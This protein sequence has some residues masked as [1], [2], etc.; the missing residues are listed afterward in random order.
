VVASAH[1][2]GEV[3]DEGTTERLGVDGMLDELGLAL[4]HRVIVA[5]G[6]FDAR[7]IGHG[8]TVSVRA[9]SPV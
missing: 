4:G 9:D 3:A 7:Y 8:Q 6:R 2:V 5:S 1:Q